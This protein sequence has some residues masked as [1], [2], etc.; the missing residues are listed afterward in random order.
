MTQID[1]AL[2][3][4]ENDR[5]L[6]EWQDRILSGSADR[7]VRALRMCQCREGRRAWPC[8][9]EERPRRRDGVYNG[10]INRRAKS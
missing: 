3:G 9:R 2:A 7:T 1:A 8:E 6:A 10:A 4:A 5:A